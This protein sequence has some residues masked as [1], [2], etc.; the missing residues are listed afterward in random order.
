L[1]DHNMLSLQYADRGAL[2]RL[3]MRL[4]MGVFYPLADV[5]IGVSAGVADDMARL[6]GISRQK[7][8]VVHN[9]MPATIAPPAAAGAGEAAWQGWK[10]PRII[11]VG[12][13]KRQKNHALLLRAFKRL[14]GNLDA[15]LMI[16]GTGEL[17]QETKALA[18]RE[19]LADRV[20]FGGQVADPLPYY[21]SSDLFVLSSD[22]EG[23][24]MVLIEALSCG[25]PVVST[26]CR[27]G[28]AEILEN[29]RYGILVPVGDFE[30]LAAAMIS[31]LGADFDRERL[32][33]RAEDFATAKVARRWLGLMAPDLADPGL[34]S[35]GE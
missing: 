19:G 26:D 10:G 34:R 29:G 6:S 31:A 32:R 17:E 3:A 30:A 4:S 28:P 11:T 2:H 1:S 35:T 12:R 27:S 8:T 25:I 9:P 5:R 33:R 20:V 21:A 13:F 23:F 18:R 16:L 7:F 14:L 22:Y 15:R 24:G